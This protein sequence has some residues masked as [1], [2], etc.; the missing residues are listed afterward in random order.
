MATILDFNFAF[1]IGIQPERLKQLFTIT[2][3][4]YAQHR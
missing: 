4:I 1:Y 2:S 3:H